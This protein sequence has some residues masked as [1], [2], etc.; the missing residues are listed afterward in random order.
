MPRFLSAFLRG[1]SSLSGSVRPISRATAAAAAIVSPVTTHNVHSRNNS[2]SSVLL[3]SS[4]CKRFLSTSTASRFSTS[5]T[6]AAVQQQ[7]Q[8]SPLA[9]LDTFARRHIGPTESEIEAMCN[10]V[11][12][13]DLDDLVSKTVPA[14]ILTDASSLA[15]KLGAGMTESELLAHLQSVARKNKVFKTYIGMGYTNTIVPPVILRNI[16][17]SP[18][19]YTQY[20]PYQPEI[21]QGRLESLLNYQTMVA[22]LTGLPI[23]NASLL[24][25]G[26]AAGEAMMLCYGS[27]NR[28]RNVF[29]VDQNVH[30]QTI[31]CVESRAEP[32]GIQVV[33]GDW[34]TLDV[35]SQKDSLMGVLIQVSLFIFSTYPHLSTFPLTI[36][37]TVPQH[38]R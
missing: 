13:K 11:K 35:E 25:E 24:D 9:P 27:H 20:T 3:L 28:K 6:T 7:Q 17:E 15:D 38:I 29:F 18:G 22:D 34:A 30:E 26:T 31:A 14:D 4:S 2:N 10:T 32:F 12:V 21:A 1:S 33:V 5:S 19:W 36:I 23:S 8:S 16:L 37:I